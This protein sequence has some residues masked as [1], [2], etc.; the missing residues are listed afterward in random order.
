[1][2]ILNY[3]LTNKQFQNVLTFFVPNSH[4]TY[5]KKKRFKN[6]FLSFRNWQN[7]KTMQIDLKAR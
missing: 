3:G 7:G 6:D 2:F 4:L 1:M 5:N